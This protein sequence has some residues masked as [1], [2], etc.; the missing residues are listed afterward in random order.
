MENQNNENFSQDENN[1]ILHPDA[2]KDLERKK[3]YENDEKKRETTNPSE[4]SEEHLIT[5]A[6][7][8]KDNAPSQ[9]YE[10]TDQGPEE[11]DPVNHPGDF[12]YNPDEKPKRPLVD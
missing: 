1:S 7:Q 6:E 12:Q 5:E 10:D 3:S 4:P 8:E 2:Q 11:I 9:D